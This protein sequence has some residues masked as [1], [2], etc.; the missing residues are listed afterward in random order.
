MATPQVITSLRNPAVVSV[1]KLGERKHRAAQGRFLVEG[2]QILELA[3]AA[4]ARP[5]EVFY[6]D[7]LVAPGTGR[8]TVAAL[9]AAGGRLLAVTPQVMASLAERDPPQGVL[10]TFPIPL[11][12]LASLVVSESDLVIVLDRLQDSGNLG[13]IIR[14]ADAVGAAAVVL[15]QP[16]VDPYDP[17]SVRGSM[18][19]LFHLPVVDAE[20]AAVAIDWLR[21][22][23]LHL[24][25]TRPRGGTLLAR[26]ALRGGTALVF[27]NESRG[28]STDFDIDGIEWVSLP[29]RGRAESLNVAVAAGVLMFAWADDNAPRRPRAR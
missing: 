13:A 24:V 25:G 20:S 2:I 3:L 14:T 23:G 21:A 27:G 28:S 12:S 26:G 17:K 18:G 11:A 5:V 15:I 1:R 19:S 10:A 8:A 22:R 6:C 7:E 16:C 4:G 29:M 9:E